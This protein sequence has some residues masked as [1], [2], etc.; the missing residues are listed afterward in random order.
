MNLLYLVY[1]SSKSK[2]ELGVLKKIN[3]QIKAMEALGS[4]VDLCTLEDDKVLITNRVDTNKVY[5]GSHFN[6]RTAMY[7]AIKKIFYVKQYDVVY[8][9]FPGFVD[10]SFLKTLK[11]LH[12][13]KAKII[14]EIPTYPFKG[15][16]IN[17]LKT[18]LKQGKFVRF[19]TR[20]M[21]YSMHNLYS[22]FVKR[23][24]KKIVTF[25]PYD[26]IW[27]IDVIALDNGVNTDECQVVNKNNHEGINMI[28]VANLAKWH[29]IDRVINGLSDYYS[30]NA[31]VDVRLTVVGQTELCNE[32]EKLAEQKKVNKYCF[33]VGSKNGND[34]YNEYCNAD[35][36]IGS[37]GMH[38]I[39]V[40]NGSTIKVKEYC[41]YG[42]PFVYSYNEKAIDDKFKYA[43]KLRAVDD[44]INIGD[45]VAFYN[46]LNMTKVDSDFL[47]QFAIDNF[48]WIN[49][50]KEV[51]DA[52]Y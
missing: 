23:Y 17:N 50:M 16:L 1:F 6:I 11:Y 52:F 26:K 34:L 42:L 30:N 5:I 46:D 37:L 3:N 47:H 22:R 25:M 12:K 49:Q 51:V 24:T 31:E 35:I 40:L 8:I 2:N 43:L 41:S 9:R 13:N 33:F 28:V 45:V 18:N 10:L 7:I 4:K 36:A 32:L 14:I 39:G 21:A 38:R 20:L 44:P 29:G 19:A 48:S 15:E 27:G